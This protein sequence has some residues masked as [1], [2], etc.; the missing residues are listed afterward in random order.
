MRSQVPVAELVSLLGHQWVR[1]NSRDLR[2]YA[3]DATGEKH[4][5][6]V[7]VFPSSTA[8]VAECVRLAGR[9]GLPVVPRGAGTN[10]SGG[11]TPL[12]GGMVINL[13]RMNRVLSVDPPARQA[14]V[15]AGATNLALQQA[16]TPHGLFF[17]PDPSSMRVSTIGGNVAEN[18]GGLHCAKYGVTTNHVL[19]LTV[20]VSDGEVVRL[21]GRAEDVPGLD[22]LALFTG[23][24]GTL[25]ILTEAVLRAL[26][27]PAATMTLLASFDDLTACGA[28]VAGLVAARVTPAALELIDRETISTVRASSAGAAG[29]YPED[30]EAVLVIDVDG[31]AEDLPIEMERVEEVLRAHRVRV[32]RH[33]RDEAEREALWSGRRSAWG[34][35]ARLSPSVWTTDVTVPR[36]RLVEMLERVMALGV[37]HNLRV[38][39]VAH[40]GDGNL[41][42]TVPYDSRDPEERARVARLDAAIQ[43]ACVALGGSITGEHG[44]GSEK[45]AGMEIMYGPDQ[46]DLMWCVRRAL[47]PDGRMNPGKAVP[48]PKGGF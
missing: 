14:V 32:I 10:L 48:A 34:S 3:Y 17:A 27:L 15:E 23:S 6:D 39:T 4:P 38:A 44:V 26:P 11:T 30:A 40:A 28:A 22:L 8:E 19:G 42:P 20:V 35:L 24:E 16:L 33:A 9:H 18:A 43:S 29:G 13:V 1:L 31:A 46:L 37:E 21:G 47:D 12:H 45:L 41:H 5:P 36:D 2:S 7:V 25:G